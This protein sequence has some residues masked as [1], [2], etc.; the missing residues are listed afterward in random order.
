MATPPSLQFDQDT[1]AKMQRAKAAGYDDNTILQKASAYQA[2]KAQSQQPQKQGFNPADLLPLVG[3]LAGSFV[4]GVGNIVGGALGA[5]AGTLFK[6]AAKNEPFNAGEALK[7]TALAGAGGAVGEGVGFLAGKVL[8]KFAGGLT[9]VGEDVGIKSLRLRPGQLAGFIEK[10]GEDAAKFLAD[11]GALGKGS[12]ELVAQHIDP[13]QQ[14]FNSI[15]KLSGIKAN[16]V[17]FQNEVAQQAQKLIEAGGSENNLI[18]KK[19]IKEADFITKNSLDKA[20]HDISEY[21][22]LRRTFAGKVNWNDPAKAAEDYALQSALRNTA[23]KTAED[24]GM[25]GLGEIGIKLS[26]F[27]DLQDYAVMQ[28]QLGRGSMPAGITKWLSV[29]GGGAIGGPVGGA[30]GLVT[31][32]VINSPEVLG[33]VSRL[34]VKGGEKLGSLPGMSAGTATGLGRA[35][36]AAGSL[37]GGMGQPTGQVPEMPTGGSFDQLAS[38]GGPGAGGGQEDQIKQ[39]LGAYMLSKA[40]SSGDLKTAYEFL[41]PTKKPLSADQTKLMASAT[42]GLR[43]LATA[44]QI[45]TQ[46]PNAP[47]KSN[48][49]IVKGQSP[50]RAAVDEV[51]DAFTRIRTGAQINESEMKQYERQLP[52]FYDSPETI[53]Y[54]LGIFRNLFQLIANGQIPAVEDTSAQAF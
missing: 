16:P 32:N 6:Q 43:S 31:N 47:L 46:D 26:K 54:K 22:K 19:L 45:L 42:S 13:L 23:I 35:G 17:T 15:A 38:A 48:L 21:D 40:K 51:K 53:R 4:P 52:Q 8:P 11:E 20:G 3:G 10:H 1:I 2:S 7:E 34:L 12:A 25:P 29:L 37:L 39:V 44:E 9:K 49:P 27:R 50:Y 30:A 36:V 5:G 41:Y 14:Q 33:G 28:E 18:A 24:A